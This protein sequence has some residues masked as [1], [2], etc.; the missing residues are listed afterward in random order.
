MQLEDEKPIQDD[1][2][3]K[4]PAMKMD[5][6]NLDCEKIRRRVRSHSVC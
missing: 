4:I 3:L 1:E 5:I 6:F 2:E